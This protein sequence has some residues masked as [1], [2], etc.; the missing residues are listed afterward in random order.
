MLNA[1]RVNCDRLERVV[2]DMNIALK[3]KTGLPWLD[4]S[5]PKRFP[6]IE[7]GLLSL[8]GLFVFSDILIASRLYV[9]LFG[10]ASATYLMATALAVIMIFVG[11]LILRGQALVVLAFLA[12]T[13]YILSSIYLFSTRIAEPFKI[14]S[15]AQFYG[16]LSFPITYEIARRKL[17]GKMISIIFLFLVVYIATYVILAALLR[18]GIIETLATEGI[19][20]SLYD[21][22][23]DERLYLASG[24]ASFVMFFAAAYLKAGAKPGIFTLILLLVLAATLLSMSRVFIVISFLI[25][26]SYLL[27]SR[28]TY[29]R[30]IA[31][32]IY[33][34]IAIYLCYGVFDPQFNPFFFSRHD[35]STLYRQREFEV[36]ANFIGQFTFFGF[37]LESSGE[38]LAR[39]VGFMLYP[40]DVGIVG[41]WFNYGLAGVLILSIIP[42]AI[43]CSLRPSPITIGIDK[44]EWTALILLGAAIALYA[45]ISMNMIVG[46]D[47]SIFAMIFG[48]TL[49]NTSSARRDAQ[50]MGHLLK[51]KTL[52]K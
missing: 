23:R 13:A 39:V 47:S 40:S 36:M 48:L 6:L 22:E 33:S 4:G 18:V 44:P 26:G 15:L 49:F 2:K 28:T 42:V 38:S 8:V 16:I 14:N 24:Q 43:C 32:S 5:P 50:A 17:F 46:A 21:V 1:D 25:L 9:F 12:L 10:V 20:T 34:A 30:L 7:F 35:T 45:S 41:V 3:P 19:Y 31:A 11:I 51:E 52:T 27:T 29:A 37:G